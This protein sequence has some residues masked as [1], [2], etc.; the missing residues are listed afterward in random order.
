MNLQSEMFRAPE[1]E[2]MSVQGMW[3]RLLK[4]KELSLESGAIGREGALAHM[5]SSLVCIWYLTAT[6]EFSCLSLNLEGSPMCGY[7]QLGPPS[8][9]QPG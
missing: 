9:C 8:S 7:T 4:C 3:K 5:R 1:I 6:A 2:L